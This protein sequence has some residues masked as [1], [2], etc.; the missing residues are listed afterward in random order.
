MKDDSGKKIYEQKIS[1]VN[2][3]IYKNLAV[4]YNLGQIA[5]IFYFLQGMKL[6]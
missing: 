3:Q 5:I 1:V 4:M 6:L 2:F